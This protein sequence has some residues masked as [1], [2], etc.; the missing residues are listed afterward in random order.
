MFLFVGCANNYTSNSK[1]F[2]LNELEQFI[3]YYFRRYQPKPACTDSDDEEANEEGDIVEEAPIDS[4]PRVKWSY[5]TLKEVMTAVTQRASFRWNDFKLTTRQEMRAKGA[6]ERTLNDGYASKQECVSRDQALGVYF[7]RRMSRGMIQ[8]ALDGHLPSWDTAVLFTLAIVVQA[9]LNCRLGDI[10][11]A[12][13]AEEWPKEQTPSLTYD[14]VKLVLEGGTS[15]EDIK[16]EWTIRNVGFDQSEELLA[17]SI[18][19]AR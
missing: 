7:V 4:K 3:L 10:L 18:S 9:D 13:N 5:N 19:Q 11:A 14:D 17:T 16:G 6:I 2:V 1:V 8:H 15:I 12:N